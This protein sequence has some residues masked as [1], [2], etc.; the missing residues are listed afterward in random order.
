MD[1]LQ[2][3]KKYSCVT[4]IRKDCVKY[5]F[6]TLAILELIHETPYLADSIEVVSKAV[7][8]DLKYFETKILEK[9]LWN[10]HQ[11]V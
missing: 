9:G 11:R 3:T 4:H 8:E 6:D 10:D 7:F 5:S 2:F 1:E